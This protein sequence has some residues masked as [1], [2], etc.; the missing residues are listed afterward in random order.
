MSNTATCLAQKKEKVSIKIFVSRLLYAMNE[1]F[2][3]SLD[4]VFSSSSCFLNHVYIL[5]NDSVD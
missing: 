2:K 5:G 4:L 3:K 1:A